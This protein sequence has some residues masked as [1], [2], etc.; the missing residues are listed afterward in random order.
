MNI[1]KLQQEIKTAEESL[2]RMKEQLKE[3]EQM[4]DK[5]YY[6]DKFNPELALQVV[7]GDHTLID[8]AF[9]WKKTPQGHTYWEQKWYDVA[10]I[11]NEDKITLLRWCVNYYRSKEENHGT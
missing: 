9:Y 1:I 10:P 5:D 6:P 11:T 3:A 8:G 7:D 4:N 2:A